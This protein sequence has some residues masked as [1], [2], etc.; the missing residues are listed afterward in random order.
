MLLSPVVFENIDD[1]DQQAVDILMSG[2]A[3]EA[4]ELDREDKKTR[5]KYGPGWGEQALLCRRLV[6]AGVRYVS[7]NTGYWD[8]HGNIKGALDS[9]MPR[10]DRAVGV[11]IEDLAERGLLENTLVVTAGEFGRT[12][13]INKNA[14]RDLRNPLDSVDIP[15]DR[16]A[17]VG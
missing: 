9:K 7:L 12:P 11:L 15:P 1:V 16:N 3:K 5:D 4:F 14:G 13:T 17:L 10:H 8:D 6:E 2:R